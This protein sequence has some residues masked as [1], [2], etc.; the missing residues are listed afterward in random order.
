[1]QDFFMSLFP[2]FYIKK[3]ADILKIVHHFEPEV[4][5]RQNGG[6]FS[7]WPPIF[8]Y[9]WKYSIYIEEW[10]VILKIVHHFEPEV[11]KRGTSF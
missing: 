4:R 6:L 11:R 8:Q 5:K 2:L 7:K 3:W 1:M 9:K 10:A